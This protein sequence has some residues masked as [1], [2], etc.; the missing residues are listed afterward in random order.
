MASNIKF[1][2][3]KVLYFVRGDQLGLITSFSSTNEYSD[4]DYGYGENPTEEDLKNLTESIYEW[5]GNEKEM[6]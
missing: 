4:E 6:R 5:R 3:D 1:P 2:E